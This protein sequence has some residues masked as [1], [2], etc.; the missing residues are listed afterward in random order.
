MRMLNSSLKYD[1]LISVR[2]LLNERRQEII[3]ANK[4]DL[5]AWNGEDQAMYDRLIVDHKKVDAM[6]RSVETIIQDLD[7]VGRSLYQFQ[8]E[9]GM[10]IVNKTA[11]FGTVLII[12]ESRPDVTI[13]AAV[14]AFKSGNHIL[15]KGGKEAIRTNRLLVECWHEALTSNNL[16][17][18]WVTLLE[19]NRE[20]TQNFLKNP[21]RSLDLIVPRGGEGLI[22][23]VKQ[24][25]SCPVLISGRGNNFI[26]VH[27]DADWNMALK[28][29]VHSKTDKISACNA[30]DKVVINAHLPQLDQ[31]LS[32]LCADLKKAGVE[33][34]LDESFGH[35]TP[36]NAKRMNLSEEW[37]KEYLALKIAI[38]QVATMDDA[39]R[40]INGH[41]GGHSVGILTKKEKTAIQ[42]MD[43]VDAAAVYHNASTRFTDGGQFGMGA[44]LAISTD[45][46]H[47]RG[48]LGLHELVTNKWYVFGEGQIR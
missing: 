25:A 16:S 28:V 9:N 30:L 23:F 18:D 3:D 17:E 31:R 37:D 20:E 35:N 39:I 41:S 46:L 32:E 34:L 15:L 36:C 1:V 44:E 48:P 11:P 22:Q 19:Y 27:H 14:V 40:L 12:Y 33:I 45:K 8:H 38:G 4:N 29:I 6:I 24:Y 13:E 26:Y 43:E 10:K 2:D 5:D 47:H 21:D 42:F 7:P